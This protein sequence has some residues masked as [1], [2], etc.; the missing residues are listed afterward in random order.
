MCTSNH[1]NCYSHHKK[2]IDLIFIGC[3][4]R[5]NFLPVKFL[6]LTVVDGSK[7]HNNLGNRLGWGETL[8]EFP[9]GPWEHM[10]PSSHSSS[11]CSHCIIIT[12]E[13]QYHVKSGGHLRLC[14]PDGLSTRQAKKLAQGSHGEMGEWINWGLQR[15][16]PITTAKESNSKNKSIW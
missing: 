6:H 3:C 10:L 9:S 4:P 13:M 12:T 15:N 14:D 2:F 7:S 1:F 11:S 8:L 5:W 16:L